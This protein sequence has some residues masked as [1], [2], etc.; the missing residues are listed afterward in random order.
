MAQKGLFQYQVYDFLSVFY[1]M[2]PQYKLDTY[3]G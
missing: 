1:N 3:I 2:D